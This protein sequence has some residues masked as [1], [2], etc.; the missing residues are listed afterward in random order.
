MRRCGFITLVALVAATQA[1]AQEPMPAQTDV[2]VSGNDGYRAYRIPAIETA[3]DGSLL[4]FAEAR[5]YNLGDPGMENNDIDL[6]VK[7]STDA[8]RTW[9]AMQVIEDPGELWSAAN[10]ATVVDRQTGRV[11]LHYLR[12]KPGKHTYV[13]RP[14]TDDVQNLARTSDDNGQTWSEPIDLTGV[15][16]D[17]KDPKW[18]CSVPGPGGAIQDRKGRLIVPIWKLAPW[19]VL[20]IFSED[21]GKTWKRG[22]TV[23][24]NRD[25]DE[26]QIVE[27]ADGRILMDYR[28]SNGA[29]RWLATSSDGGQ[30]WT[31][32][33]PGVAVT[34]VCCAIER[35]T[36]K[37]AGDD[38]DRILWTGP[39]GPGRNKLVAR[40]S[41]DEG[42][43]FKNERPIS[44]EP[45]AYSDL[46]ILKDKSVGILWERGDYKF[47]TFTRVNLSWLE[48]K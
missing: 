2:F 30:S 44:D 8:G 13:A 21:H 29:H 27:L 7:R 48:P 47:I 4:A 32:P 38:S 34:P 17:M 6:V 41:Y 25:G 18:R 36:L 35:L 15:A 19:G 10:A 5:K 45:A 14:G 9:S 3:P 24:G 28:Q 11:W 33:R 43:T 39:K 46:T 20:A 26:N 31:E 12:C 1:A 16:R 42:Q 37:S 40:T 23:P 22:Q